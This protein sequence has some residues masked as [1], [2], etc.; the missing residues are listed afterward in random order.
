MKSLLVRSSS[1]SIGRMAFLA[2]AEFARVLDIGGRL[3]VSVPDMAMLAGM[4]LS[5]DSSYCAI[6]MI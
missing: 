4:M 3:Q 2:C 6:G 1:T 5:G